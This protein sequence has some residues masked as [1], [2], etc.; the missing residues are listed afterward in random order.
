MFELRRRETSGQ[1]SVARASKK[2]SMFSSEGSWGQKLEE[3]G[4]ALVNQIYI[5]QV[6]ESQDNKSF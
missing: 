4:F 1:T 5:L 6:A 2:G 3:E